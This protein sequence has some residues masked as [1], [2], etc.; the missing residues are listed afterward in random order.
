[1]PR[2]RVQV[3]GPLGSAS[4]W[5]NTYE[6]ALSA[7]VPDLPT[8]Q[9]IA[10]AFQ[11]NCGTQA[12][13][14]AGICNDT[15]ITSPK[16][17]FYPDGAARATL[18]AVGSGAA[19]T[20]T[21][22]AVHAP[23]VCVVAS[24]RSN[25]AGRSN[26]GRLFVPYRGSNIS[27]LGV[28]NNVAQPLING[29]VQGVV[30]ALQAAL[31]SSSLVGAWVIYSEKNKAYINVVNVLVG[32]QCDTIRHRN[33]NRAEAYAAYPV[34]P[35]PIQSQSQDDFDAKAFLQGTRVE[36]L[37]IDKASQPGWVSGLIDLLPP[38]P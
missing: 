24:L 19:V 12:G 27:A 25:A 30:A 33:R 15:S 21:V 5:S 13:V 26:R 17:L 6:F 38:G 28:V 10:N 1:M 34:T 16:L 18:V 36:I 3:G 23:Q 37:P 4:D 22:S 35:T 29:H 32:N 31:V 7:N 9:T 2:L 14:K 8:L 20:G 11:A